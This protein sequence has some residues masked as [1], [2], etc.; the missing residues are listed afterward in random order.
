MKAARKPIKTLFGWIK[1]V[2]GQREKK[3]RRRWRVNLFRR[4]IKKLAK[5]G[6]QPRDRKLHT[7]SGDL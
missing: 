7:G 1:C 3:F 4:D 5:T 2:A 6:P